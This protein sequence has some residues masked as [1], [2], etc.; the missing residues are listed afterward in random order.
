MTKEGARRR[1]S[2][3]GD[4]GPPATRARVAELQRELRS[5]E[6]RLIRSERLNTAGRLAAGLAH[7]LNTPLGVIMACIETALE[8]AGL[9]D[10]GRVDLETSLTKARQCRDIVAGLLDFVRPQDSRAQ[11]CDLH[12]LL[13]SALTLARL[14]S[15]APATLVRVW[16]QRSA[17]VRADPVQVRQIV[18]NLVRNAFQAVADRPC[19]E[20]VVRVDSAGGRARVRVEDN[21]PGIAAEHLPRLFEPFFTTKAPE[22]GTGL[23]LYLCRLLAE[24]NAGGIAAGN[25]ADGGAVFTLELAEASPEP[26]P[27]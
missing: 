22:A 3:G 15:S 14:D 20:V 10:E 4:D 2:D 9:G 13:E 8:Q 17:R 27:A 12:P 16:P 25:R 21:G 6:D 19:G 23:G 7:E 18:V 24:R 5:L 26:P 1:P 11:V